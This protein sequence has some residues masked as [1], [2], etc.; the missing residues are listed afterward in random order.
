MMMMLL[1]TFNAFV[2]HS[3][4]AAFGDASDVKAVG[5]DEPFFVTFR[6]VQLDGICSSM[7]ALRVARLSEPGGKGKGARRHWPRLVAY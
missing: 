3:A 1:W 5:E 6:T 7:V 4:T 2:E